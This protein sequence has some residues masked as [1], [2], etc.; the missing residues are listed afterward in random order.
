MNTSAIASLLIPVSLFQSIIAGEPGAVQHIS[1][2]IAGRMKAIMN[3]ALRLEHRRSYTMLKKSFVAA[4]VPATLGALL[5]Y[6]VAMSGGSKPA[7]R[8]VPALQAGET[9]EPQAPPAKEQVSAPPARASQSTDEKAI[10]QV[11]ADYVKAFRKGDVDAVLA[12]WDADA[13]FIDE[14]GKITKGREAIGALLRKNRNALQASKLEIRPTS[15]RFLTPD[16]AMVDANT[17]FRNADGTAD[18]GPL[19]AVLIKKDGRWLLRSVRDLP[20]PSEDESPGPY[21]RLKQLEW[22]I[23]EWDDTNLEAEVHLSCRWND[24]QSFLVQRYTVKQKDKKFF[25]VTQWV[26]WDPAREQIR[27]WFFDS[28][29][30]FGEGVW[31]R[32]GNQWVVEIEGLVPDGDTGTS[33]NIWRFVDDNHFVWQAKERAVDS[34][35]LADVEVQFARQ[36]AKP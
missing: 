33:R 15:I 8:L 14:A 11:A 35:P 24:D 36:A 20:E 9:G 1:R 4:L 18:K 23:G 22:L 10:R 28:V 13:E 32:E 7:G 19:T 5:G 25:S 29:G 31:T 6:G 3:F 21:E 12:F 30:G 2:T 26:G 34:R 27:S 17:V 16:V